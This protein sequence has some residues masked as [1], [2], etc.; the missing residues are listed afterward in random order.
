MVPVQIADAAALGITVCVAAGDNGNSD[1]VSD[2]RARRLPRLQLSRRPGT[3][4][5]TSATV[6]ESPIA[7]RLPAYQWRVLP[8]ASL[9]TVSGLAGL[10][11]WRSGVKR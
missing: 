6:A 10:P 11:G 5:I 7:S 1:G 9:G 3:T 8:R 4:G 2:G